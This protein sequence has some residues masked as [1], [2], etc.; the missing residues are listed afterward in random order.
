[1]VN[2][3]ARWREWLDKS[4][5]DETLFIDPEICLPILILKSKPVE[6]I[7]RGWAV[8]DPRIYSGQGITNEA[9]HYDDEVDFSVRGV[10]CSLPARH[11]EHYGLNPESAKPCNIEYSEPNFFQFGN[12]RVASLLFEDAVEMFDAKRRTVRG[13][14]Q[15]A[16]SAI[17]VLEENIPKFEWNLADWLRQAKVILPW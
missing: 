4:K 12:E 10:F 13:A 11:L 5:L 7:T 16:N 1:M 15:D 3:K 9:D 8:F 6:G 17:F 2:E 14:Y